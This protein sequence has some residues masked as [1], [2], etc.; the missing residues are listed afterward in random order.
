MRS[1]RVIAIASIVGVSIVAV[2]FLGAARMSG[3]DGKTTGKETQKIITPVKAGSKGV[4]FFGNGDTDSGLLPL[5]PETFPQPCKVIEVHA[6]EGQT[7]EKG[8]PLVTFDPELADLTVKEAEA[9]LAQA[10]GAQKRAGAVVKAAEHYD[11]QTNKA[12]KSAILVL[13][14]TLKGKQFELDAAKTELDE[15]KRKA[16]AVGG[17]GDPKIREAETKLKA[18]E[19]ALEAEQIKLAGMKAVS[20]TSKLDEAKGALQE[21]DGAVAKQRATLNKAIYGQ[22]LMVLYAPTKGRIVRSFVAEGLTFGAQTRQ[23]AFLFQAEGAL[24]VRAEVDQEFASRVSKDQEA[25]IQDESNPNI[26]WKGKVLRVAD[27]FLPKRTGSMISEGLMLNDT[28][29]LEC[30]ISAIPVET[31]TPP[32]RMG[33]RVKVSIG[34]E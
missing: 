25:A 2:T 13:E 9:G 16:G 31:T 18:A 12:H 15:A 33:Q 32:L 8:M 27:G 30:I 3:D 26:K 1:N 10:I 6:F 11:E 19:K 14:S 20:P 22:K 34:V 28:R 23:P 5:F 24:I 21:A 17:L 29:V 7:V 4:V